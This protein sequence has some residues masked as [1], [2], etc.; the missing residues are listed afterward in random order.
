MLPHSDH[1]GLDRDAVLHPDG[2][3]RTRRTARHRARRPLGIAAHHH[4]AD[5]RSRRRARRR[6]HPV[7]RVLLARNPRNAWGSAACSSPTCSGWCRSASS[8]CCSAPS[9]PS[10]TR[11][12]RSSS[13]CCSRRSSSRVP[14]PCCCCR[15]PAIGAGIAL[16]TSLAGTVQAV[17]MLALLRRRLGGVDG[18]LLAA[19][20]LALRTRWPPLPAAAVG[21]LLLL[22][23][24]RSR[25]A[26]PADH[27][28]RAG[29]HRR[30]TWPRSS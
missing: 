22:A 21:L 18:R 2:G 7:R 17:V 26:R 10:T 6:G 14:S 25:A 30:R 23:L 20:L 19:A 9:T 27:R 16:V 15:R 1:R 24:G 5:R 8:S 3:T 11:A 12:R 28:L 29:R 4:P 13:S